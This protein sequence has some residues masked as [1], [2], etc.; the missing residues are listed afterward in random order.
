MSD[1][2]L[3]ACIA[4][5]D[6]DAPRLVWADAVGGERGE[7]VVIQCELARGDRSPAETATLRARQRE[8][9]E[10]R[11]AEWSQLAGISR[12]V[13][14]RRGFVEAALLNLREVEADDL[15]ARAPLVRSI[16][17]LGFLARDEPEDIAIAALE[18]LLTSAPIQHWHGLD[19]DF[20]G[21]DFDI[22]RLANKLG[23]LGHLR[24][25]GTRPSSA[26]AEAQFQHI[27]RLRLTGQ[28]AGEHGAI[29]AILQN[30]KTLRALECRS[31]A[32]PPDRLP[33][34][35]RE[36]TFAMFGSN[37]DAYL[38]E[39]AAACP[40]IERL[41]IFAES[42]GDLTLLHAFPHLRS[43]K[44]HLR[45]R[46]AQQEQLVEKLVAVPMPALRELQLPRNITPVAARIL[47]TAL[48][49]QLEHV[50]CLH[51]RQ[52]TNVPASLRDLVA[53]DVCDA[54]IVYP[55][56]VVAPEHLTLL[57]VDDHAPTSW[58]GDECI[59]IRA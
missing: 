22:F 21:W 6:D 47:L 24:S 48:G 27:E 11:G 18:K 40:N 33:P 53:G 35:L 32:P 38:A 46:G 2:L 25:L 55:N 50:D 51:T 30:A 42:I 34:T 28:D 4:A 8:L 16:Q 43:L 59:L 23:S 19:L 36:L 20:R 31:F 57:L 3:A 14:F 7:F 5:P 13:T 52:L 41:A 15:A 12:M 58:F 54:R 17:A 26:L 56:S 37:C 9:L 29:P 45:L 39:L 44:L 1:E 49:P 10:T